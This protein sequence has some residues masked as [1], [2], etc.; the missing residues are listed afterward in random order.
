LRAER[1][2][3]LLYDE[4]RNPF[5]H[6]LGLAVEFD[7]NTKKRRLRRIESRIGV[8]KIKKYNGL[9]EQL[10]EGWEVSNARPEFSAT[11]TVA[12]RGVILLSTDFIGGPV[13]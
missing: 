8:K 7:L 9:T 13:A 11:I 12:D 2:S 4:F 1:A 5:T 3:G 6:A 10:L